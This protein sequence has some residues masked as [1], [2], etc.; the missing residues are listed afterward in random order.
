[1]WRYERAKIHSL[2]ALTRIDHRKTGQFRT[3]NSTNGVEG[4]KL[5]IIH[6]SAACDKPMSE[7]TDL[8]LDRPCRLSGDLC[9]SPEELDRACPPSC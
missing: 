4:P 8:L 9:L 7:R 2:P 6:P 1:M 5:A 3:P